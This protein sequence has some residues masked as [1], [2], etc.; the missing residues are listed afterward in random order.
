LEHE[1]KVSDE[2]DSIRFV[3]ARDNV[4]KKN[5]IFITIPGLRFN[6]FPC[7]DFLAKICQYM[8]LCLKREKMEKKFSGF[9][10]VYTLRLVIS[11]DRERF[12]RFGEQ[13]RIQRVPICKN[14]YKLNFKIFFFG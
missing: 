6:L 1:H 2:R 14:S 9:F 10:F 3:S 8:R 5:S 4:P 7:H 13:I 12:S 11:L